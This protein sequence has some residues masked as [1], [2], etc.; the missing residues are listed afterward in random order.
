MEIIET[1]TIVIHQP[2]FMA[3]LP[4]Y[5]R[6]AL[7][8]TFVILDDVNFRRY[9]FHDRT[10]IL[11]TENKK[12]YCKLPTNGSSNLLIKDVLLIK[13]GFHINKLLKTIYLNYKKQKYFDEIY[14]LFEKNKNLVAEQEKLLDFN[15]LFLKI[16]FD[17]LN[18]KLPKIDYSSSLSTSKNRNERI[19]D[20]CNNKK[21]Q[22]ILCGW[23][24]STQIHD[25]E[26]LKNNNIEFVSISK[27]SFDS[28]LGDYKL[29]DGIS[30]I[31]CLMKKGQTGTK[32]IFDNLME[33]Y[34]MT[35][36]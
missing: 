13:P 16:I 25:L 28:I 1:N 29:I 7:T 26:F 12:T 34:K 32:N 15:L 18:I 27:N 6:I 11:S 30:I 22:K 10:F 2:H 8:E 36:I 35:T 33:M 20:I 19:V 9:S 24:Q 31:D 5:S 17:F 4:Y 21:K 3:W 23:G 14:H